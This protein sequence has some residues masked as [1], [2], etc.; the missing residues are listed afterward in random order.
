MSY[1]LRS[2]AIAIASSAMLGFLAGYWVVIR[3][4]AGTGAS[5]V[6]F[7]AIIAVTMLTVLLW[8]VAFAL[9]AT[10]RRAASYVFLLSILFP[11]LFLISPPL[12][13]AWL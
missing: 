7:P 2:L 5:I 13:R 4:P 11:V 9:W 1:K 10:S 3:D 6:A 8:T 12:I